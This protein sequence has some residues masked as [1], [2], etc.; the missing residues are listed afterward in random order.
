MHKDRGLR[1]HEQIRCA[2]C[3]KSNFKIYF[4]ADYDISNESI[5]SKQSVVSIVFIKRIKELEKWY[6]LKNGKIILRPPKVRLKCLICNSDKKVNEIRIGN[7]IVKTDDLKFEFDIEEMKVPQLRIKMSERTKEDIWQREEELFK[8]CYNLHQ[9]GLC[10]NILYKHYPFSYDWISSR[11]DHKAK[12]ADEAKKKGKKKI[13]NMA[14][15]CFRKKCYSL[16]QNMSMVKT[17]LYF[18]LSEKERKEFIKNL[19]EEYPKLEEAR[20]EMGQDIS[21]PR[22]YNILSSKTVQ[23]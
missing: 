1:N 13:F 3:G 8:S 22:I 14:L 6:C 16:S 2:K 20:Q 18:L 12:I 7:R 11:F 15:G 19:Y 23:L 21:V 5:I 17:L 9:G 4:D 10:R